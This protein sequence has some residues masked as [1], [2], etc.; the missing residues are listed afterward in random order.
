M[1]ARPF[2]FRCPTAGKNPNKSIKSFLPGSPNVELTLEAL[3]RDNFA[4]E[5]TPLRGVGRPLLD[6][7]DGDFR[8]EM[9][10]E[11]HVE[12]Y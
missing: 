8:P 2:S 6:R 5:I 12:F 7:E 4:N 1:R 9:Q 11:R 3:V 10:I